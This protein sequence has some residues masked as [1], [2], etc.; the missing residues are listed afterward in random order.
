MTT[1][2]TTETGASCQ[3]GSF[4]VS[5]LELYES[6]DAPLERVTPAAEL[7]TVVQVLDGVVVVL[8][9]DD[10]WILTPGDTATIAPGQSYRRWNGGEDEARWVEVRCR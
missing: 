4:A 3:S 7:S 8:A 1:A 6:A 10:E 2:L 5:A 9:G